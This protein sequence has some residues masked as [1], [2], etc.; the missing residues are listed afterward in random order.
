MFKKSFLASLISSIF[1]INSTVNAEN[2]YSS[3]SLGMGGVGVAVSDTMA[4][5]FINPAILSSTHIRH[6]FGLSLPSLY[7]SVNDSKNFIDGINDFQDSDIV[8]QLDISIE[9]ARASYEFSEVAMLSEQLSAELAL[10]DNKSVSGGIGA[11]LGVALPSEKIGFA[12]TVSSELHLGGVMHFN[13]AITLDV[14]SDD[15]QRFD[16]CVA[17]NLVSYG[18][19][20]PSASDYTYI[21]PESG[22][23]LF[24]TDAHLTSSVDVF[25]VGVSSLGLSVS[26]SFNVTKNSNVSIGLTP[27]LNRV[28]IFDYTATVNDADLDEFDGADFHATKTDFNIDAG[29]LINVGQNWSFGVAVSDIIAKQYESERYG[30]ATG[31]VVE[32]KPAA[33]VGASYQT[34]WLVLAADVDLT[35]TYKSY[36]P[37]YQLVKVGAEIDAFD[38]FQLRL[39]YS[40][41]LKNERK[42]LISAGIGFSPLGMHVDVGVS[43]NSDEL[44]AGGQVSFRY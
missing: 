31:R 24:N 2:S 11:S 14:L 29:V 32:L 6:S 40:Y 37:S 7:G 26:T 13:D 35:T 42:D 5:P 25:G 10:L 38:L 44:V 34:D 39:G 4:G 33:V 17:D 1:L 21:N 15:L 20:R 27:K 16:K 22:E 43:G 19:C 28:D 9:N 30:Q 18:S 36:G 8:D 41:D 3:R 12:V 23:I